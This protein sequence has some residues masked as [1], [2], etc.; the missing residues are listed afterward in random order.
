M[1]RSVPEVAVPCPL[2]PVAVPCAH[3]EAVLRHGDAAGLHGHAQALGDAAGEA[4]GLLCP[5][6]AIPRGAPGT[7][8]HSEHRKHPPEHTAHPQKT[9]GDVPQHAPHGE[10]GLGTRLGS[11]GAG[12]CS[13]ISK[14]TKPEDPVS[15]SCTGTRSR[16]ANPACWWCC[17][18]S[19]GLIICTQTKPES[20]NRQGQ[21]DASV[22]I[23]TTQLTNH[24][25]LELRVRHRQDGSLQLL[26]AVLGSAH[27]LSSQLLPIPSSRNQI[28][29]PSM[30]RDCSWH[31]TCSLSLFST[32]GVLGAGRNS[33]GTE[34]GPAALQTRLR[35]W[36]SSSL[37]CF[38]SLGENPFLP[39]PLH[40]C[41]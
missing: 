15:N 40:G 18:V 31:S 12:K 29:A 30:P 41:R 39:T 21:G 7:Q 14:D 35:H 1:E 3:R 32:A 11:K 26:P 28:K 17:G 8:E 24:L 37:S 38:M 23:R 16:A 4:E 33:Q 2:S 34:G 27:A 13:V 22:L 20:S 5:L 9:P 19:C 25:L 10:Q 6:T 36:R